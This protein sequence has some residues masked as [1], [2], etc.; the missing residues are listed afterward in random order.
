MPE[1]IGFKR[2][3]SVLSRTLLAVGRSVFWTV[4]L[5]E[6]ILLR[7]TAANATFPGDNGRIAFASNLTWSTEI[8]TA[9]PNGK[10]VR[11]L[12]NAPGAD[13]RPRWSADGTKIVF[14][15]SRNGNPEIYVMNADGTGQTRITNDPAIDIYGEWSP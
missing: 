15:S 4:G 11:Q 8:Y 12:T 7:P 3:V 13:S 2:V 5:V 14:D 10:D 6:A 9:K 1:V